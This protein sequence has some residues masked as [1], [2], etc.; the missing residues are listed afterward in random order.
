MTSFKGLFVLY[1]KKNDG[2]LNLRRIALITLQQ[3]P[4]RRVALGPSLICCFRI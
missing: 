4:L 1:K 3:F 2:D